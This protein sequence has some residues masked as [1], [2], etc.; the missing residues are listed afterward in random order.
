MTDRFVVREYLTSMVKIYDRQLDCVWVV[1]L[2]FWLCIN[3][4]Q[5]GAENNCEITEALY[6]NAINCIV[7]G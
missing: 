6:S 4:T 3:S 2:S 1:G 7:K 5:I